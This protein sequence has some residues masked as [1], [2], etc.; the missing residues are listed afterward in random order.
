M[1]INEEKYEKKLSKQIVVVA[2]TT[3][4]TTTTIPP[5]LVEQELGKERREE[6]PQKLSNSVTLSLMCI[7]FFTSNFERHYQLHA[8]P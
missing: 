6:E 4:S 5:T 3:I 2:I 1:R 8:V 7:Q